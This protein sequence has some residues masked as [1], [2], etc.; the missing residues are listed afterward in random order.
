MTALPQDNGVLLSGEFNKA[1]VLKAI[2]DIETFARIEVIQLMQADSANSQP[3]DWLKIIR[4]IHENITGYDGIVLLHGMDTMAFTAAA[5]SLALRR[6]PIPIVVTGS[7]TPL[8]YVSSDAKRNLSD[9]VHV[10]SE[11]DLAEVCVVNDGRILRGN[12]I[13]KVTEMDYTNFE[14]S[15][16]PLGN[17][18]QKVSLNRTT[19]YAGRS[20]ARLIYQPKF[21]PHILT[22]LVYPGY[23]SALFRQIIERQPDGIL[24]IGYGKGGVASIGR[25]SLIP[26]I[27]AYTDTGKP[28]V[29]ATQV[30]FGQCWMGINDASQKALE[31][32]AICAYDMTYETA[33]VKLMWVLAQTQRRADVMHMMQSNYAGEIEPPIM[34]GADDYFSA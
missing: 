22:Q 23:D 25:H 21:N 7:T 24:L 12:R 33:I 6:L 5:L 27:K 9:A 20:K 8:E 14:T 19:N 34:D 4:A 3:A 16:E 1:R 10:A 29:I 18:R 31:A 2:P 28:L 17:V 11:A 15:I 30:V 32:G 26:H 13:K